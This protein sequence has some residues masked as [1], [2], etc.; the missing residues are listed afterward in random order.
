ME[1]QEQQPPLDSLNVDGSVSL[2]SSPNASTPEQ[3]NDDAMDLFLN[4][5]ADYNSQHLNLNHH[6]ANAGKCLGL[7]GGNS[8]HMRVYTTGT[9][10]HS[11]YSFPCSDGPVTSASTSP[12]TATAKP[13]D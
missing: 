6:D 8:S 4:Q 7:W 5:V 10:T 11:S 3:P 1:S 13:Q 12:S 9:L 2:L